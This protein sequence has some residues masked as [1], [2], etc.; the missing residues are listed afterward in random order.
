[1]NTH[2]D[3]KLGVSDSAQSG[4]HLRAHWMRRSNNPQAIIL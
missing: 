3:L 4:Q 2:L 1:M